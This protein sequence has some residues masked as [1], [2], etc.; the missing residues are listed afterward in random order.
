M[1]L[2]QDI[3]IFLS[4]HSL[5]FSKLHLFVH[6]LLS[7]DPNLSLSS[8]STL[9]TKVTSF[10]HPF[11]QPYIPVAII[12]ILTMAILL[13][14]PFIFSSG[15]WHYTAFLLNLEA[16]EISDTAS[17]T[18]EITTERGKLGAYVRKKETVFFLYVSEQIICREIQLIF[19][20]LFS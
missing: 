17:A 2:T 1:L 10:P 13:K 14:C 6:F 19:T 11:T 3:R 15:Y 18:R 16:R 5:T 8:C 4:I 12:S 20:F 9:R 7:S